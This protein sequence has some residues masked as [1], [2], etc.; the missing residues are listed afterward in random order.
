MCNQYGIDPYKATNKQKYRVITAIYLD[1]VW[2]L[3]SSKVKK[4]LKSAKD[5]Y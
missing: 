3:L 4:H 5:A 2:D 1:N